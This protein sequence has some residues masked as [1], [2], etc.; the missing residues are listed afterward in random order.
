MSLLGLDIGE[1]RCRA[2]AVSADGALLGQARR[3]YGLVQTPR[4]TQTVDARQAW[5]AAREA[6]TEAALQTS[7]D[8]V[9]AIGIASTG[10]ALVPLSAE[11]RV[12]G[13][14][15]L[16]G[17]KIDPRCAD[18]VTATLGSELF[19][20]ITGQVPS[21]TS[22]LGQLCGLREAEPR[23]YEKTWRFVPLSSLITYLL[24]GGAT[25]DHSLASSTHLFDIGR[26]DWSRQILVACRLHPLKL[27]QVGLAGE[28]LGTLSPSVSRDLGL[29]PATKL[30]RGG[31]SVCCSAL[32]AGVIEPG[33]AELC[34]GAS[35]E[36]TPTFGALPLRSL[37]LHQGLSTAPHVVAHLLTGTVHSPVG[38]SVLRWYRD[39]LAPLEWREAQK[40]GANIYTEL[41][42]EMPDEP[43]ELMF[44]PRAAPG[45]HPLNGPTAGALLGLDLNTSRGELVKALLEG[46]LYPFADGREQLEQ[47]GIRIDT[48]CATGGGASSERWLQLASDMLGVPVKRTRIVGPAPLGAAMLAGIGCG[49]YADHREAA[50][51]LAQTTH[52][53]EPDAR[54]AERY[55]DKRQAYRSLR[56]LLASREDQSA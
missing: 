18:Q 40:L 35:F 10:A 25:C 21:G 54:R 6:L 34:L 19:F 30:V 28:P 53:C 8:P 15:L 39:N 42:A 17:E 5:A 46:A 1:T 7:R 2:L 12:L 14:C 49:A 9:Q 52:W 31:M 22:L 36:L 37:M 41:L 27:P 44:L 45:R 51:A 55:R 47:M 32:G 48:C 11:G 26:R 29:P 50:G 3:D 24:G 20:D 43:T 23:L 56:A 33:S 38:G 16:A 13:H 4:G